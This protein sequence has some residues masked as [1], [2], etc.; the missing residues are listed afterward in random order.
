MMAKGVAIKI[1]ETL[2]RDIHVRATERSMS[3]HQYIT[4]LIERNLHPERFPQL[5]E[6]QRE[7]MWD[8]MQGIKRT[9]E[10]ITEVMTMER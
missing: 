2:L 4:E 5:S 6:D 8:S 10:D 9:I 3:T 7:K 1:D